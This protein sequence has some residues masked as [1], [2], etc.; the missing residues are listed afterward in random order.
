MPLRPIRTAAAPNLERDDVAVLLDAQTRVLG[1]IA[2]GAPLREV[3]ESVLEPIAVLAD[4][5]ASSVL[6]LDRERSVLHHGAALGLP[7]AYVEAIDGL[8]ARDGAGSCGTAAI[9]GRP[10]VAVDVRTDPRWVDYRA[11]ADLAELRSC[12]STPIPGRD[13]SPVGSFAVYRRRPHRPTAREE[14]VVARLTHLAAVAIDSAGLLGELRDSEERF[15]RSFDDTSLG[16][17]I[18][19]A[20]RRVVRS[21]PA[22]QRLAGRSDPLV[23]SS[24]DALVRVHDRTLADALDEL[25]RSE[26]SPVILGARLREQWVELSVSLL[27]GRPSDGSRYVVT[28]VD[29]TEK[30]AAELERRARREAE[31]ARRTAEEMTSAKSELLAAVSHDARTPM[32]AIVGFA[33]LLGTLDLDEPRR[34]EAL[35]HIADAAHHVMDLLTD[36]LDLSR[37]EAGA[38]PVELEPVPLAA[39]LDEALTMVSAKSAGRPLEIERPVGDAWVLADRRRLRQ[40]LINLLDNGVRHGGGHLEVSEER[41]A[42]LDDDGREID[43]VLL[44]LRDH[45]PGLPDVV[46]ARVFTP[47]TTAR[48]DGAE[49]HP[50]QDGVGL[51]LVVARGLAVAL[52][53]DLRVESTGA[54]GTVMA[55]RLRAGRRP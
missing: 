1:L 30:R 12:W 20:E 54:E 21:N 15:R 32:Q 36:M 7:A 25:D 43:E 29:L 45:G 26:R 46:L 10:V 8:E 6:L 33:E 13:G 14:E 27:A 53:G 55:L 19:D 42:R 11:A 17:A 41:L 23:G 3:L 22:P 44:R 31:V 50:H 38:L 5:A 2:R 16:M 51:G 48:V 28:V 39:V 35:G 47:F 49:K 34:R 24:L 52:D 4:D 9:T 37:I 40:V 18:L